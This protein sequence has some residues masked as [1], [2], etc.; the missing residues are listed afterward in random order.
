MRI[1]ATAPTPGGV[2]S[3]AIV[4]SRRNA[5]VLS[6]SSAYVASRATMVLMRHCCKIDSAVFVN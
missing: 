4:S 1:T 3:A 2:A 6:A 5:N